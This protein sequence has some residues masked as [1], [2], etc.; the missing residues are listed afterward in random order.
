M[1]GRKPHYPPD[2]DYRRATLDDLHD[3]I[4]TLLK[5]GTQ[6][7][8]SAFHTGAL[9]TIADHGPDVRTVV[10]RHADAAARQIGCHT[11]WRSPKRVQVEN[12]TRVSWMFYDR[13]RKIQLRLRGQAFLNR[14][15]EL[16]RDRWAKSAPHSQKCY[17]S[18]LPPG[19]LI[20]QPQDAP[21]DAKSGWRNFAVLLCRVDYVD[22]L[23]LHANGHRRANLVWR[24]G[25]WE[26][27][28]V[29]P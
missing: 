18:P 1:A 12:Q 13:T 16:A 5:E 27:F 2:A 7:A 9:A 24:Q 6:D 22:W 26:A 15:N 21:C 25:V 19:S 28:W 17:A 23:F 14:E 8:S 3:I 4:W 10:L 20:N 11:D 29:S